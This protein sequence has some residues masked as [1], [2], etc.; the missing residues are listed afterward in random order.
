M[1]DYKIGKIIMK[2]YIEP[3]GRDR[4]NRYNVE[5]AV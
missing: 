4:I 2:S 1:S 3:C 5:G